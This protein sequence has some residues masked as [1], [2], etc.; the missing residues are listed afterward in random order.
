PA[1][2]E[3]RYLRFRYESR[4]GKKSEMVLVT[5]LTDAAE[6]DW[7]ELAELYATRWEIELKLRDLK[8]TLGMERFE[9]KSPAM[10]RKTLRLMMIAH[11][12]VRS[13]MQRAAI[14]SDHPLRALSFKGTLDLVVAWSLPA[15]R[16]PPPREGGGIDGCRT[17][18]THRHQESGGTPLPARTAGSE[19]KAEILSLSHRA[20]VPICRDPAPL[21]L[22]EARPNLVPFVTVIQCPK[23]THCRKALVTFCKNGKWKK[24]RVVPS[25]LVSFP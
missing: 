4:D 11:N 12:L 21:T 5:T 19:T 7:T 14:G 22:P 18:R 13:M 17:A 15:P 16:P 10:A 24:G 6:I 1:A 25:G 20:K 8:T 9:V 23:W 3:V 2:L